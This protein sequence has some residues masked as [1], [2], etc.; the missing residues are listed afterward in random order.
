MPWRGPD[1]KNCKGPN[2]SLCRGPDP[3]NLGPKSE[4]RAKGPQRDLHKGP[5]SVFKHSKISPA[6]S[7]VEN[8][9]DNCRSS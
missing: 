6:P 5:L 1:P 2:T 4:S 9:A 3:S 7:G 8:E